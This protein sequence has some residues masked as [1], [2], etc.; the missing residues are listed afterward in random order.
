VDQGQDRGG[1]P[2]NHTIPIHFS[3][4]QLADLLGVSQG[5]ISY[6]AKLYREV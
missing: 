1:N 6:V 4:K 3:Q 5:Y 2:Q